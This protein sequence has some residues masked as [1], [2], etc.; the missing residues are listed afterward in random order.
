MIDGSFG[1]YKENMKVAEL[2]FKQGVFKGIKTVIHEDLLPPHYG[3]EDKEMALR[4]FFM[5]RMPDTKNQY[6]AVAK[7]MEFY[8]YISLFDDYWVDVDGTTYHAMTDTYCLETDLFASR[9]LKKISD[10]RNGYSPNLSILHE[11]LTLFD[12]K[13]DTRYYLQ[14]YS[15]ELADR[16]KELNIPY[17]IRLYCDIPFIQ[18][19]LGEGDY[20]PVESVMPYTLKGEALFDKLKQIDETFTP[21]YED[22][23]YFHK[24]RITGDIH[25][26]YL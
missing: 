6:Y 24:D 19:T 26:E 20:F 22:D 25:I 14:E 16:K 1:F 21:S 2:A 8:R 18:T 11:H 17:I 3:E 7:E 13:G 23:I 4:R 5:Y 10:D 15:K 9:V 12:K